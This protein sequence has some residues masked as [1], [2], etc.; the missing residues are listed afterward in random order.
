MA[1]TSVWGTGICS[2]AAGGN[3][4]LFAYIATKGGVSVM[5]W[6]GL[7][8]VQERWRRGVFCL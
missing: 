8:T 7:S 1:M 4:L 3:N 2:N 5:R 6:V